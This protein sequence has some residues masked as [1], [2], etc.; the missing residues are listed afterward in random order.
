LYEGAFPG[1]DLSGDPSMG[2]RP[3][4]A[5]LK[6]GR[7][8]FQVRRRPAQGTQGAALAPSVLF[9][10]DGIHRIDSAETRSPGCGSVCNSSQIRANV[11]EIVSDGRP[12]PVTPARSPMIHRVAPAP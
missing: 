3:T 1:A 8:S 5:V 2:L 12:Q 11:T 9:T 10:S 4:V 7:R 6:S